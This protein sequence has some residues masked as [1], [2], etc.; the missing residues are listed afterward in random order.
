MQ[1][2]YQDT[3]QGTWYAYYNLSTMMFWSLPLHIGVGFTIVS[4]VGPVEQGLQFFSSLMLTT[5]WHPHHQSKATILTVHFPFCHINNS[6]R[7]RCKVSA[8]AGR[9]PSL[10]AVASL[11]YFVTLIYYLL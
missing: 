2:L 4:V 6:Q 1:W 7:L 9:P 10:L 8:G 11:K 3:V 5:S